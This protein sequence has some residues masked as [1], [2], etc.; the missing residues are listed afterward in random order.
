MAQAI[1]KF[2]ETFGIGSL[3]GSGGGIRAK[4]H[5]PPDPDGASVEVSLLSTMV[6][7]LAEIGDKTQICSLIAAPRWWLRLLDPATANNS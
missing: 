7:G 5:L 6:V 1:E 3:P 2:G 4:V